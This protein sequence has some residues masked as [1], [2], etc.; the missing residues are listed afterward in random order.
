M[1]NSRYAIHSKAFKL[2]NQVKE[3]FTSWSDA[4]RCGWALAKLALGRAIE[5]TFVKSS[6]EVRTARALNV[7]SLSTIEKGF[8]RFVEQLNNG[9]TQWRSFKLERLVL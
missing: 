7:G 4:L 8:V 1:K 2:A 3:Y 6:G 5:L 9:N